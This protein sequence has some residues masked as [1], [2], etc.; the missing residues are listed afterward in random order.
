MSL[1]IVDPQSFA[2]GVIT[3]VALCGTAV[4]FTAALF[5]F[6]GADKRG[7]SGRHRP[8]DSMAGELPATSFPATVTVAPQK[9]PAGPGSTT[10]A[11]VSSHPRPR[12]K[13]RAHVAPKV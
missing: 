9:D 2:V 5:A 12:R 13:R 10:A 3:G 6:S 1:G 7:L 4:G 11:R 8:G